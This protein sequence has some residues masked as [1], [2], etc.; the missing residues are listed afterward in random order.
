MLADRIAPVHE[1]EAVIGWMDHHVLGEDR[2]V[3]QPSPVSKADRHKQPAPHPG[4]VFWIDTIREG[5]VDFGEVVE[6]V[7]PA[8]HIRAA[9]DTRTW[10]LVPLRLDKVRN[11][12]EIALIAAPP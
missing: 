8:D 7:K 2:G 12:R 6:T 9:L 5:R 3:D 10:I 4:R 11:V 1:N